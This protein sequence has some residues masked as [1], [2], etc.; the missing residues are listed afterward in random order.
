MGISVAANA[1][2][3]D[4]IR[5]IHGSAIANE[6]IEYS[7]SDSTYG[8]EAKGWASNANY[9]IKK[10]TLLLFINHRAVESLTLKK[11]IEK[12]YAQFLPKGGHPFIYLSLDVD[13]A[14]VDVNVHPTKREVHFLNEDEII[15]S[16]CT[17]VR[18]KLATVDTSRTFT[19]Q[20]LLPGARLPTSSVYGQDNISPSTPKQLS[21]TTKPYENN[22]VR[23]DSKLRKITS[24]LPPSTST[25]PD[26]PTGQSLENNEYTQTDRQ[27]ILCRLKTVKELRAAI[28]ESM[29]HSLTETFS[30]HTFVG[31]VDD[32]RRIAAIQSGVKL[33]L[34]DYGMVSAEYFY[35]LGLTDFA[36]FGVI[37]F[38]P[39]LNLHSLL[40]IGAEA[41][42]A[43]APET[44]ESP[45]D[46]KEVISIIRTQ[47]LQ[48]REMLK[49]YFNLEIS[50]EGDLISIPL[51]VRGYTP[52]LA[53]LPR[54]LLNLGPRVDWK[55]E[56]N[57]F[58]TFLHQLAA[59]YVPEQLPPPPLP[60]NTSPSI[61]RLPA[62][63]GASSPFT[64]NDPSIR[65][66]EETFT[67]P[68]EA[69]AQIEADAEHEELSK[70]RAHVSHALEHI[71]FPAFRARL[72]A[73]KPLLKGVVEV[74]DLKGLYRVFERC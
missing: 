42:R 49:E 14:R 25:F 6:L 57:C 62:G 70:R 38:E 27:P 37:K 65:S 60:L 48:R 51:L 29:H 12:T 58:D 9:H 18:T 67:S 3:A 26:Q 22:L 46:W 66:P 73:T 69:E 7:T 47:L 15:E 20:S 33:L 2:T 52:S 71:L 28:R 4:R 13:P 63:G 16:I 50:P 1:T 34:I 36:N 72:V 59:F 61:S 53:K 11:A 44:Q 41:E 10:T 23:T 31:I 40:T 74:A 35:Q 64:S 8:F 68:Q 19:T 32:T 5:Q 55:D 43:N 54:F 21:S 39:S 30:S 56:K 17:A 45:L 24:M